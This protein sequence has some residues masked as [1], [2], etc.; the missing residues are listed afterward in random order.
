MTPPCPALILLA[1]ARQ[2]VGKT[3]P[4]G[5][6][7]PVTRLP[8]SALPIRRAPRGTGLTGTRPQYEPRGRPTKPTAPRDEGIGPPGRPVDSPC[9]WATTLPPPV[10]GVVELLSGSTLLPGGT[11]Q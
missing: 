5:S 1:P 4:R 3:V 11:G 10:W 7:T 2:A 9:H 8:R 6:G